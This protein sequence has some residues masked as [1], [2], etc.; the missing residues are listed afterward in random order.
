MDNDYVYDVFIS[1]RHG[2]AVLSWMQE[3][4]YPKLDAYL[5]HYTSREPKIFIDLEIETGSDWPAR[6]RQALKHSRCLLTVWSA[7]YFR[8][9]WCLAELHSMLVREKQVGLRTES[10]P[11][12]LIYPVV[13]CDGKYFPSEYQRIQQRRDFT[14]WNSACRA[15]RD[16][17]EYVSFEQGIEH[18]CVELDEMIE[19]A[20]AWSDWPLVMPNTPEAGPFQIPRMI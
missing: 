6:L 12:G 10:N 14:K 19:G 1:Y 4:F 16:T 5:R 11:N 17:A 2:G 7:D 20:P 8:S 9:A 3:H 13:F 15:F 18:L